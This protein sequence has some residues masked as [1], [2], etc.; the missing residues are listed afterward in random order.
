MDCSLSDVTDFAELQSSASSTRGEAGGETGAK[1]G[2]ETGEET[3]EEADRRRAGERGELGQADTFRAERRC[4]AQ[5][6]EAK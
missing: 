2:E 5:S 1:A 3:D 4:R 6:Q